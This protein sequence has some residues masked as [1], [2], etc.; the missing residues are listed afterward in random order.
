MHV[1]SPSLSSKPSLPVQLD[2]QMMTMVS[3]LN[4]HLYY[5]VLRVCPLKAIYSFPKIFNPPPT[6]CWPLAVCKINSQLT[7]SPDSPLSWSSTSTF[8]PVG[9]C[10]ALPHSNVCCSSP[11]PF[12]VSSP[13][14]LS[15]CTCQGNS[16]QFGGPGIESPSWEWS[17]W[18]FLVLWAG[19]YSFTCSP[20]LQG[21]HPSR[22]TSWCALSAS[23]L[24]VKGHLGV[25]H[26]AARLCSPQG[27]RQRRNSLRVFCSLYSQ[28][29]W[30]GKQE[31]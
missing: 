26:S 5:P 31:I 29:A 30:L 1:Q 19:Y 12:P 7:E 17:F 18:L 10:G 22:L 6:N 20:A 21:G 15:P 3:N 16:V 13:L 4:S 23:S 2:A 11:V 25:T 14:L 27:S 9:E 24:T 28:K 8:C